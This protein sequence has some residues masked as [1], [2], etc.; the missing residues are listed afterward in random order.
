MSG[1]PL[2]QRNFFKA[3]RG[4]KKGRKKEK[5]NGFPYSLNRE[6]KALS[7]KKGEP[8]PVLADPPL[9]FF[10]TGGKG[11]GRKK[12]K[13]K[14]KKKEKRVHW[15][16]SLSCSGG[17]KKERGKT[18]SPPPLREKKSPPESLMEGP[19]WEG[20]LFYFHP[21]L[22]KK[23]ERGGRGSPA[24]FLHRPTKRKFVT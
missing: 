7:R 9:N 17:K 10:F 8:G 18:R 5:W 20:L 3:R 12:K 22:F 4:K 14:K 24:S 1:V 11:K 21:L 6:G 2:K 13:V 23:G 19:E 16:R 15:I